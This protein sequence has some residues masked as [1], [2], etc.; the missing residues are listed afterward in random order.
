MQFPDIDN[1]EDHNNISQIQLRGRLGK[2]L[3]NNNSVITNFNP[4]VALDTQDN[5]NLDPNQFMS[6]QI[7]NANSSNTSY[8]GT[9]RHNSNAPQTPHE[10]RI[11]I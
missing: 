7:M 10:Q 9:Q 1:N 5:P 6:Q 8:I 2:H 11:M 4:L 3:T